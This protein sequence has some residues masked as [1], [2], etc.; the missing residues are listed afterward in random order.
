MSIFEKS[1]SYRPFVY[2]E[3]V[4]EEKKQRIEMHWAEDQADLSDD[5]RQYHTKDGLKTASF[6]HEHNKAIL[7]SILPLFTEMDSAVGEGYTKLLPYVGNNEARTLLM[8]QSAREV[9]HFRGYALANESFGLPESS[10][11]SFKQYKEMQE[12]IDIISDGI[13]DLGNKLNWCKKLGAILLGEGIGLFGSFT[14]LLNF[15]RSG[16]L[17]GFNDINQWS[18]V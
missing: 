1:K 3:F 11:V 6:S 12:K 17:M 15:K 8:V 4:V 2:P 14:C 10:W 9:T 7:E 13:G 5:L 18:L 16:L